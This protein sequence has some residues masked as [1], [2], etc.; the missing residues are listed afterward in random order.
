MKSLTNNFCLRDPNEEDYRHCY[1]IWYSTGESS[2][3]FLQWCFSV[4]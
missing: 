1:R 4:L 3:Y 2:H